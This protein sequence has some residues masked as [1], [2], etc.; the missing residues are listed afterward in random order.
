MITIQLSLFD[1]NP[2]LYGLVLL[3]QSYW[4][5]KLQSFVSA[6]DVKKPSLFNSEKKAKQAREQ[7]RKTLKARKYNRKQIVINMVRVTPIP[8]SELQKMAQAIS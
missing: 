2:K 7:L 6:Y 3:R 8:M 1:P 5:E 4:D